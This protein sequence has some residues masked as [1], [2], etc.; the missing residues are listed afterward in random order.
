M[1]SALARA[2]CRSLFK[3]LEQLENLR[4]QCQCIVSLMNIITN[5]QKSFQTDSSTHNNIATNKHHFPRTNDILCFSK[6]HV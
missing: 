2:S 3:H 5:D 6:Q 1:V 4:F